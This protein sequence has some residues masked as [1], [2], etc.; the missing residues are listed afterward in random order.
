MYLEPVE[1]SASDPIRTKIDDNSS[2]QNIPKVVYID[3]SESSKPNML[4]FLSVVFVPLFSPFLLH[5]DKAQNRQ[6][7]ENTN[8]LSCTPFLLGKDLLTRPY[9]DLI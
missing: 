1:R 7:T 6:I 4:F 5:E 3:L 8:E 2:G 9:Y